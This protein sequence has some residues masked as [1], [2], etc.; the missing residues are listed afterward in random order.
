MDFD[1]RGIEIKKLGMKKIYV[2]MGVS[3]SG[4]S[5][6]GI[7]ISEYF[8]YDFFDG[9]D[10]HPQSN[11]YK[12]SKGDQ[13]NDN[14]REPWLEAINRHMQKQNV[15]A[16]YAC[17]ALKEDYRK[18]LSQNLDSIEFIYLKGDFNQIH[19]RI[20]KRKN[21]FMPPHLLK[22]Q[23]ETLEEPSNAIVVDISHS[24]EDIIQE[25]EQNLR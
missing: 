3:G 8:G 15:S 17:S 21:H 24:I 16:I 11:I 25:L 14:D 7:K 23:F 20:G 5:T 19:K 12:M 22:S 2:I 13:L 1:K 9:D 10:F 4:K 6:I 18:L